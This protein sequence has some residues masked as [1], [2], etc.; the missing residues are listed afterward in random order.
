MG[1]PLSSIGVSVAFLKQPTLP[2]E[3]PQTKKNSKKILKIINI[4]S[5]M[6]LKVAQKIYILFFEGRG[7]R[8]GTASGCLKKATETPNAGHPILCYKIL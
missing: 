2:G 3:A 1:C 5:Q 6:N 4:K 7:A 8:P